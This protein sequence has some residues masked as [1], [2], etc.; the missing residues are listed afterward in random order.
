MAVA[1]LRRGHG[2][3]GDG[4][5]LRIDLPAVERPGGFGTVKGTVTASTGG[6]LG[7]VLVM[8]DTGESAT[9]N[10]GGNYN[11]GNVPEGSRTV[12]AS[13]PGYVTQMDLPAPV[14]AGQ[15][16]TVNIALVPE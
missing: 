2:V 8:T 4:L 9:T 7:G 1:A 15:T 16:T 12:T 11:I 13:K 6:R 14:T 5:A 3:H 10:N